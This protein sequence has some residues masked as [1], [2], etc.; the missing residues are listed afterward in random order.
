M[1]TSLFNKR[2]FQEVVTPEK[3]N[4]FQQLP[5]FYYTLRKQF[6][7]DFVLHPVSFLCIYPRPRSGVFF[8]LLLFLWESEKCDKLPPHCFVKIAYVC[9]SNWIRGTFFFSLSADSKIFSTTYAHNMENYYSWVFTLLCLMGFN[10][11]HTNMRTNLMDQKCSCFLSFVL[12]TRTDLYRLLDNNE[13]FL[14]RLFVFSA[15]FI[16]TS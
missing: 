12:L 14:L 2:Y 10:Y 1:S 6:G 13:K 3:I 7:C 4:I 16:V 5:E 8:L 15:K 11:R 9:L